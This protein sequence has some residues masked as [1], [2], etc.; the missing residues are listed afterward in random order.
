MQINASVAFVTGANRGLGRALV[1]ALLARG[2]RH[3]YAAGRDL[4]ALDVVVAHDPAR[5]TAIRFDLTDP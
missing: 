4:G 5:I 1:D 3:V 2:A